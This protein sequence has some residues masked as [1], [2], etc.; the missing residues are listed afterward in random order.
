MAATWKSL[1]NW[2]P[3]AGCAHLKHHIHADCDVKLK[4]TMEQPNSRI[5]C[6]K[7]QHG[8]TIIRHC[9]SVL[10]SGLEKTTLQQATPIQLQRMLQ[11]HTLQLYVRR[12]THAEHNERYAMQMKRM[13]DVNLLHFIDQHNLDDSAQRY[14]HLMHALTVFTTPGGPIVAVA[15]IFRRYFIVLRQYG[16]RWRHIGDF[17]D[18]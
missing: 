9:H 2:W 5:V 6:T 16:G 13:T 11:I 15:K 7:P 17:I 1:G 4:M 3:I 18:Q 10:Q 8:I 12:A 14:V